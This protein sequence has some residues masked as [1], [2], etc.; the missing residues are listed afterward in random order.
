MVAGMYIFLSLWRKVYNRKEFIGKF[1]DFSPQDAIQEAQKIRIGVLGGGSEYAVA[2]I[3][4]AQYNKG[5]RNEANMLDVPLP[6]LTALTRE[7][8]W[9]D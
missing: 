3:L 5:R 6:R 1:S 7:K 9:S 2:T 8:N 4:T